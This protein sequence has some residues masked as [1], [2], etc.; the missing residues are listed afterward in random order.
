MQATNKAIISQ[1]SWRKAIFPGLVGH[2][3]IKKD[4]LVVS[5]SNLLPSEP[6]N[7]ALQ[8]M[9]VNLNSRVKT[10]EEDNLVMK[11][12]LRTLIQHMSHQGISLGPL[13]EVSTNQPSRASSSTK[14]NKEN[15]NLGVSEKFTGVQLEVQQ[16][17]QQQQQHQQEGRQAIKETTFGN[18]VQLG[19][20]A[21]AKELKKPVPKLRLEL[22]KPYV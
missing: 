12:L 20:A 17:Q 3:P 2:S 1:I 19:I 8:Q 22:V 14:H 16:L 5:D 7:Q 10:L 18:P 13:L 4:V 21:I 6:N 9:V 11:D 15:L